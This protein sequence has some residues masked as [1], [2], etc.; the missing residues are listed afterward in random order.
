MIQVVEAPHL[1]QTLLLTLL[2]KLIEDIASLI[3][4][5]E[6]KK[7]TTKQHPRVFT[8]PSLGESAFQGKPILEQS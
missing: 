2:A 7:N 1:L 4:Q 5:M 8:Q 3:R 6:G